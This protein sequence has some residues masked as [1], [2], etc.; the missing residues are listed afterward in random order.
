MRAIAIFLALS[1]ALGTRAGVS[2]ERS[3]HHGTPSDFERTLADYKIPQVKLI[4]DDGVTVD[5]EEELEGPQ[6]VYLNFIY[7]SCTS[8]CPLI[9]QIFAQLQETLGVDRN[10]VRMVS[11]SIDP[12]QDTLSRL[13]AFKQRFGAGPQWRFYTGTIDASIS[14]QR[15]FQ[16]YSREKMNHPVATF[17]RSA[18]SEPWVRIAGFATP[19]QLEREYRPP[20][21]E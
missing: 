15:A 19:E 11:V 3:Q 5:F 21:G 20:H 10:K 17:Y 9:S 1:L 14:V 18:P 2:H 12:E 8:V 6:P 13:A 4:R 7:T 16:V